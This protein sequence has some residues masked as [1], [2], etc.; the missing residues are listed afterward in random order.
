MR[1]AP[2]WCPE[3]HRICR[4]LTRATPSGDGLRSEAELTRLLAENDDLRSQL[5]QC[6]ARQR[7]A[8]KDTGSA[9]HSPE[10]PRPVM[11][12][13]LRPSSPGCWRRTMTCAAS[14]SNAM[15]A[16]VVPRKTPDLQIT[17]PSH[18]VR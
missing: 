3:R 8:P 14:W 1:C 7:G 11:A 10:P 2:A 16:S 12:S 18:P 13:D 6:D 9:D 17:H 5:E 4:S 15:R